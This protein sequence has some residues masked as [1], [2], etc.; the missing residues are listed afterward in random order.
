[1]TAA[2]AGKRMQENR[3]IYKEAGVDTDRADAGLKRLIRNVLETWPPRGSANEVKL[4]IN[5]FANVI[6]FGDRGLAICTDGIGSKAIIAQMVGE[7]DTV[8]IDCVAMNVNDLICVGAR[9][10][11]MVDYIAVQIANPDLLEALSIGLSNG[12]KQ[13]NVSICGGEISQIKD[14]ITGWR[15]GWGFDLVGMA[16][17]DVALDKVN[18]GKHVRPGDVVVGIESSG[19]H[20]NGLSLARRTFFEEHRFGIDHRFADLD[21]P[22]GKELLRPTNIYVREVLDVLNAVPGLKAMVHITSD[23]L[24]NLTRVEAAVGYEITLPEPPPIFALIERYAA[25]ARWE[26]LPVYNMGI[27]FCL[28]VDP[29]GVDETMRILQRHGRSPRVIGR[30]VADPER[31]VIVDGKYRGQGKHFRPL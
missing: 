28:V 27:G 26:M 5:Y 7:Y 14:I 18:T 2:T 12:A 1:M 20:S 9:P 10:V 22:L 3:D 19:V 31:Q 21:A 25:V 23:G 30:A 11:S 15:D 4:P 6:G 24:L 17:G 16:V 29:G 8:G 13:A